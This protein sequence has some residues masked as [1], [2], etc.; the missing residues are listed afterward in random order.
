MGYSFGQIPVC[1]ECAGIVAA[2][3]EH[4]P[5]RKL[6]QK[7]FNHHFWRETEINIRHI[8]S[9]FTVSTRNVLV[10]TNSDFVRLHRP[11]MIAE[12]P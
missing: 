10:Y 6:N 8:I 3:P 11:R 7:I 9:K 4:E 2:G 5:S 1:L 12:K